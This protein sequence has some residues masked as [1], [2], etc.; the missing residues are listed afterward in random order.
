[1]KMEE[2]YKILKYISFYIK[3]LLDK[4]IIISTRKDGVYTVIFPNKYC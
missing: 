4:F 3:K 1:M 2:G